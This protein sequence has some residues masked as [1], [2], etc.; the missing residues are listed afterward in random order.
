MK[1]RA[2]YQNSAQ[3]NNY[4]ADSSCVHQYLLKMNQACPLVQQDAPLHPEK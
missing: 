2:L 4:K 1:I 3:N